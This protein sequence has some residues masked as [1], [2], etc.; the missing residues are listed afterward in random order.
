MGEKTLK[1]QIDTYWRLIEV[2]K[3]AIEREQLQI[4]NYRAKLEVLRESLKASQQARS[5]KV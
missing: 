4:E 3:R 5:E 2:S 1:D